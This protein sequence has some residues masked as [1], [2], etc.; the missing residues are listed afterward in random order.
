MKPI[1]ARELRARF[2]DQHGLVTRRE[3]RGLGVTAAQERH[4]L[5]TGEWE[6]AAPGVI[7]LAGAPRTPEQ[8]LM[9][10]CLAAGPSGVASH[11]SAAWLWGLLDRAPDRPA[12]TTSRGANGQ[13][14]GMDVH[15]PVDYPAH[16]VTVRRI[17]CTNPL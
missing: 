15:R 13:L 7:R 14:R 4:R 9:A 12:V 6:L 10:A 8:A 1:E 5:A 16:M 2:R 11:Q 17:P 3:S